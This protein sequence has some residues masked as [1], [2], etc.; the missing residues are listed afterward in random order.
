M[1]RLRKLLEGTGLAIEHVDEGY[2]LLAP[3][4]FV[5]MG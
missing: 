2:R 3:R 1:R 4:G 5:W